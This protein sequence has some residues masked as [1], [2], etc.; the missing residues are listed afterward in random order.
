[1][2]LAQT[3]IGYHRIGES[4]KAKELL[5]DAIAL[6]SEGYMVKKAQIELGPV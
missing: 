2:N 6:D 3:A 1:M 5:N 4:Q